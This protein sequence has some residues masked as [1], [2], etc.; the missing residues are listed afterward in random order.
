LTNSGQSILLVVDDS[1]LLRLRSM[2]LQMH[3]LS[4]TTASSA[5]EALSLC[6]GE[7]YDLV[8]IDLSEGIDA[9][10]Q[11]CEELKAKH[12]QEAVALMAPAY[13]YVGSDCPDEVIPKD[14]GPAKL[15]REIRDLLDRV[16]DKTGDSDNS[17]V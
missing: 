16:S 8:V 13:A 17:S 15:V 11:L 10:T 3:G 14:Q 12:R 7:I 5:E 9:S 6:D 1:T 4:V 2:I